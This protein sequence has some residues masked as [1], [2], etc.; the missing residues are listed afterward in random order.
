VAQSEAKS[1]AFKKCID[2]RRGCEVVHRSF[3]QV[4]P[5]MCEILPKN[6][7]AVLLSMR[8]FIIKKKLARDVLWV[9]GIIKLKW[10]LL[11]L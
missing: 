11:F 9:S 4:V 7:S 10:G 3:W 8:H 1:S 2:M 6:M 5:L